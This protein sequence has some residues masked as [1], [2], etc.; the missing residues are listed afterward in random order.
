M[1]IPDT[2]DSHIHVGPWWRHRGLLFLNLYLVIPLLTSCINGYDSSLVNGLQL[3]RTWKT[4]FGS[5]HGEILGIIT[6]TQT[7]GGLV[8]LPFAPWCSD[9]FGRRVTLFG[10]A[11]LM[12]AGVGLQAA[13][14]TVAPFIGARLLI[15]VGLVFCLNAAPLLIT[16]LAYPTQRGKVT[17]LYNT[18]WFGGS[19]VAAW[20][21]FF[22]TLSGGDTTLSLKSSWSWRVPVLIQGLGPLL[23]VFLI[24]FV[25]E[26]PRWLISKGRE[27][28]AARILARFH[29]VGLDERNPLVLFQIAQIRRSLIIEKKIKKRVS[30]AT[31]F[32]TPGNRKRMRIV[33]GLTLFS[34]WS[35]NGLASFYINLM[36]ENVG[37]SNPKIKATVNGCLQIW[38]L[39]AALMGGVL[40]NRVRRRTL[41]MVSNAVTQ[42]RVAFAVLTLNSSLFYSGIVA[43]AHATIP[44]IFFIH[45]FYNLAYTPVLVTYT[46]EIL[47]FAIRAKGFAVVNLTVSVALALNQFVDPWAFDRMGWR[48]ASLYI[49]FPIGYIVYCGW[50]AFELVFVMLFT[51][52]TRGKTPE[53]IAVFF[54]GERKPN[55]LP[56]AVYDITAI[57]LVDSSIPNVDQ[58]ESFSCTCQA[59]APEVYELK[60]PQRVVNRDQ[61]GRG[62][63]RV[64]II[65]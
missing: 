17:S 38:N 44:I 3:L 40:V 30:F 6:S 10:G 28:K 54:D 36:L 26:S 9:R 8:G 58:D 15:G 57:S 24:W 16:E 51:V 65:L 21:C 22:G 1:A 11:L 56:R 35:G 31:L 45:L 39:A 12:L 46:L 23:Q 20:M 43:G 19:I 29:S 41:F 2:I 60:K 13:S 34:Q 53:E 61:L 14:F 52:E 62:R 55:N 42:L 4:Q 59:G 63:G 18:S 5:P 64:R 25:P 37:I 49:F 50:L 33:L 7:I 48:Y 27:R 32:S 47:P